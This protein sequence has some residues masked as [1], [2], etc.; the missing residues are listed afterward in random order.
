MKKYV[1]GFMFRYDGQEV[2]LVLKNKPAFQVG[3][4]NAIGGKIENDETPIV[5][6]C[7]EFLEE[8]GCRTI[9]SDWRSFCLLSGSD[10]QVHF[11]VCLTG[12]GFKIRTMEAEPIGW[13]RITELNGRNIAGDKWKET[14]SNLKWLI[15]LAL[16]K[17][18]VQG[19]ISDRSSF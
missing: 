1:A 6:M 2:A 19:E 8:T 16:D 14:V 9:D 13:Y 5:A 11:F 17:D 3:K 12:T 18:K 15:P 7:R 10:W 4:L